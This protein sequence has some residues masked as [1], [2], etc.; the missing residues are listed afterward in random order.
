MMYNTFWFGMLSL[1]APTMLR[2]ADTEHVVAVKWATPDDKD[3]DSMREF[4]HLFNVIDNSGQPVRAHKLGAA[5]YISSNVAVYPPHDLKMWQLLEA[6]RYAEAQAEWDRVEKVLHPLNVKSSK[7]SG[8][9]RFVKGMMAAMGRPAGPTR[10]PTLPMDDAE[11][12]EL[13]QALIGLGWVK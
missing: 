9:Y 12:A 6:K 5:G 11:V 4:S 8:G 1:D 3:Y 2:L 7:R 13:R 10:P